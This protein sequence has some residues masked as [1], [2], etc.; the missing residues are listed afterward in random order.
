MLAS[1][2]R[3]LQYVCRT[4]KTI[5]TKNVCKCDSAAFKVKNSSWAGGGMFSRR[6]RL[7]P[8]PWELPPKII[9]HIRFVLLMMSRYQIPPLC[10]LAGRPVQLATATY[11]HTSLSI[12]FLH[13]T[14]IHSCLPITSPLIACFPFYSS[15][16]PT[17]HTG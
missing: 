13:L 9:A 10:P 12:S 6:P 3:V 17:S 16:S 14:L 15:L 2:A 11:T 7:S 1:K 8:S 5:E 4:I